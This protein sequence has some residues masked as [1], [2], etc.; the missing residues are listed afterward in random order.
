M[1]AIVQYFTHLCAV[2]YSMMICTYTWITFHLGCS[3][4]GCCGS[5]WCWKGIYLIL[6]PL[7]NY[8]SLCFLQSTLLQCLLKELPAMSGSVTLTGS[9]AFASQEPWVFSDTLKENILFGLP[10]QPSWYNTV[11]EA[12]ALEKVCSY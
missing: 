1:D 5:C 4:V 8:F 10:F 3:I 6:V 9:V 12:C 11:V 7:T 2:I